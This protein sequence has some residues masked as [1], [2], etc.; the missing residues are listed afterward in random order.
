[1]IKKNIPLLFVLLLFLSS[2]RKAETG[3]VEV[4]ATLPSEVLQES[5]ANVIAATY[6][7]L[8]AK[9]ML[10]H[11]Q[12]QDFSS[13]TDETHLAQCRQTW[14]DC[15][16]AWEQSEAFLF[17]PVSAQNIDPRIDTWPV[18]FNDLDSV[19]STSAVFTPGYIDNLDDALKGFHPVEYL[20]F[21][22]NGTK[23]ASVFTPRELDYLNALALNL[24]TL[25]TMLA[26]YWNA[27]AQG[28]Y[29][30]EFVNA[31]SGSATYSTQRSAFEEMTNSMI[32]ICDEVA[33]G[34][35]G[36]PY[37]AQDPTLEESPYSGNSIRDF[38]D[39]ILGVQNLYLGRYS[40]NGKGIEDLV[41]AYNLSL[42]GRVKQKI[43]NA[44]AAL[45]TVTVP[46]GQAISQ[47][48]LQVQN[49]ISAIN[50]LKEILEEELLPFIQ[51]HTN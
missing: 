35:I 38:S 14:R 25:T 16:S 41:R 6:N 17:G 33:N 21:G 37:F 51:Q 24:E 46:F 4:T 26:N 22:S 29:L 15:R 7:D 20:L 9:A 47:Q 23:A 50:E 2:C 34:K 44:Q 12:V 19:L 18:N 45:G 39:N 10:L 48:P 27:S 43:E 3:D 40:A 8:A 42:D 32:G 28:N 49:C 5:A 1:M 13:A 30:S 31:G 36:E 11:Q